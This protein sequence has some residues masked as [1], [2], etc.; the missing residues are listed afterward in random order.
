MFSTTIILNLLKKRNTGDVPF[1]RVRSECPAP[2]S[3]AVCK[4]QRRP[5]AA[6]G[7]I[8]KLGL[9]WKKERGSGGE[10][11]L[12]PASPRRRTRHRHRERRPGH[13]G[14]LPGSSSPT[15]CRGRHGRRVL[16]T[17]LHDFAD[18]RTLSGLRTPQVP[19]SST[20]P[21]G[22]ARAPSTT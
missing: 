8:L 18:M 7:Q 20:N 6:P 22:A 2:A 9:R 4:V 16:L 12:G 10:A 3:T 11:D 1:L 21:R 5:P 14:L 13:R 15:S 17:A 19:S